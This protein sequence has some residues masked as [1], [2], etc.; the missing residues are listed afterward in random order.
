M[1]VSEADER[2]VPSQLQA[3]DDVTG[4][5]QQLKA[6][7]ARLRAENTDKWRTGP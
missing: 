3:A 7:A 5:L 6:E 2:I 4:D 1:R